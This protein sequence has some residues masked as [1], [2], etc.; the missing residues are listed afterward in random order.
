[1][2]AGAS[3]KR[4]REFRKLEKEFRQEG[5]YRGREDEVAARIV[6]KQRAQAGETRAVPERKNTSS[7]GSDAPASDLPIA[8]YQ[9]LTVAQI[10]DKL[11]GLSAAQLRRLRD[12]E[13]AHKKRKGVL[14]AL[15]A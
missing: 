12:Y 9:H 3:P 6:N 11:G 5:R 2:P 4:E 13:A 7:P 8:G 10:R 15:G 14:Q 1:M